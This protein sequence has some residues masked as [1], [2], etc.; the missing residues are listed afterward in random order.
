MKI[1]RRNMREIDYV[2]LKEYLELK[3]DAISHVIEK[4]ESL[5][6][7]RLEGMNQFRNQIECERVNYVQRELYETHMKFIT[8]KINSLE[9]ILYI[10]M[11]L[12]IAVEVYLRW[13]FKK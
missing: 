9:K 6:D 2:S 8:S 11:G 7:V 5:L 3:I 10:G 13:I 4:S 12:L 1:D